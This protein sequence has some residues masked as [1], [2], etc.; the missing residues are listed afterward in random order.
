MRRKTFFFH[1]LAL[2][3]LVL[4][5]YKAVPEATGFQAPTVIILPGKMIAMG[6]YEVTNQQWSQF[7]AD[8][9]FDGSSYENYLRHQRDWNHYASPAPEYPVVCVNWFCATAYCEWL[10]GKTGKHYRL[11]TEEEWEYACR[12]GSSKEFGCSD[13]PEELSKFAWFNTEHTHPVGSKAPNAWGL[14]D[15]Q[16]NAWEWCQNDYKNEGE[17]HQWKVFRGGSWSFGPRY[18]ACSYH[19]G[20]LPDVANVNS[21]FRVVCELS[22]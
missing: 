5:I 4:P 15:L 6:K 20:C 8:S 18:C 16:G 12:S 13:T 3:G 17:I 1:L 21:G 14:Y 7:V 22:P 11:P 19:D 9:G 10:S 2:W